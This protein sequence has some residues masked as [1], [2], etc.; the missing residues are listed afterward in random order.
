MAAA[1]ALAGCGGV[2]VPMASPSDD[3]LGRTF[4]APP[5]NEG[6]LYV[7]RADRPQPAVFGVTAGR[8]A[9]GELAPHTW[10]RAD[11]PAGQHDVRCTGGREGNQSIVVSL[12]AGETRYV[13][14]GT[15]WWRF[16]CTMKE[17][18]AAAARPAILAGKRAQ[19]LR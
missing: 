17:V 19:E 11:L 16:A 8:L 4:P 6:A 7:Y 12:P 18:P 15:E 2:E 1:F 13:E 3:A 5:Q 14:L 10:L 9:L